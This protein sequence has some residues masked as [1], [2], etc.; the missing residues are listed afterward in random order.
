[1]EAEYVQ[2]RHVPMFFVKADPDYRADGWLGALQDAGPLFECASLESFEAAVYALDAQLRTL[3]IEPSVLAPSHPS[4]AEPDVLQQ[5]MAE[6]EAKIRQLQSTIDQLTQKQSQA[7]ELVASSHS[8]VAN[9]AALSLEESS[10]AS[11]EGE[12]DKCE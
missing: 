3:G 9:M 2:S 4:T 6:S 7:E 8:Q 10:E 1:M 11:S 12:E 5:R